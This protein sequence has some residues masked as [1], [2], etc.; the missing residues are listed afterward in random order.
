MKKPLIA[1]LAVV[2]IGVAAWGYAEYR[3][4]QR[5]KYCF[6]DSPSAHPCS[7]PKKGPPYTPE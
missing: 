6:E 4:W 2:S 1:L 7:G 3:E 5:Y